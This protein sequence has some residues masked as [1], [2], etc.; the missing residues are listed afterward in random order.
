MIKNLSTPKPP[1]L[2]GPEYSAWRERVSG[3]T[4]ERLRETFIYDDSNPAAPLVRIN[5]KAGR[6][7]H[8]GRIGGKYRRLRIGGVNYVMSRMVWVWWHGPIPENMEIDHIDRDGQNNRIENLRLVSRSDNLRNMCISGRSMYRGV[9]WYAKNEKWMA[10]LRGADGQ[11]VFLG[12]FDSEREASA[13]YDAGMRL[14]HGPEHPHPSNVS[15]GLI[16]QSQVDALPIGNITPIRK[17]LGITARQWA[18]AKH[19]AAE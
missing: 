10:S 8:E 7:H 4:M 19:A 2:Y 15:E 3:V 18:E 16:D 17:S 5:R 13:V 11:F 1:K 9:S 6:Q 14:F 12:Y